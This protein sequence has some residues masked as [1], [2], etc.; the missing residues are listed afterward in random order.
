MWVGL[1]L[2]QHFN[3]WWL[4][5]A[6][7]DV[8]WD[9]G[10]FL[11]QLGP[12]LILYLQA[13]ALVT[14]TPQSV[15]SWRAHFYAIHRRFFGLNFFFGF[16]MMLAGLVAAGS[17]AGWI[18]PLQ[19]VAS[20]VGIA[21]LSTVGLLS[22]SHRVQSAVALIAVLANIRLVILIYAIPSPLG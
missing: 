1:K 13:T 18:P 5:W 21:A 9:Y 19:S 20:A 8:S 11:A 4:L 16:A 6:S 12:P 14:S 17:E 10:R 15:E 22:N 2:L 7:R 3:V